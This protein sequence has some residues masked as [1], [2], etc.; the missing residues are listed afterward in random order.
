MFS[1]AIGEN[2][3]RPWTDRGMFDTVYVPGFRD[4]RGGDR[5]YTMAAVAKALFSRRL[6]DGEGFKIKICSLGTETITDANEALNTAAREATDGVI[7]NIDNMTNTIVVCQYFNEEEGA[8]DEL[9]EVLEPVAAA[10]PA[11][12]FHEKSETFLNKEM[13]AKVF[14]NEDNKAAFVITDKLNMPHWHLLSS[15][16]PTYVPKLFE[17]EPLRE[18]EK[19]VLKSMAL[20]GSNTFISNLAALE[21]LYDI[22]GKKIESLVSGFEVRQREIQVANVDEEIESLERQMRDLM[23]QYNEC[24]VEKDNANI[25][26]AGLKYFAEQ[27]GDD[28]SLVRFFKANKCLDV[29][30]VYESRITFIVRTFYENFDVDEYERFRENPRFF[31]ECE[32][33]GEFS[34]EENC[35]KIMDAM[36]L[37]GKI[38]MRMCAVYHLD[39]RGYVST[40]TD[41]EFPANCSEYIPNYHLDHHS[42]FGNY[43][44]V[45]TEYLGK[46]DTIGAINACIA[47]AKSVNIAESGATFNPMMRKVFQS[48]KKCFEL[49]D[50]RCVT[51]VEALKWLNENE[52]GVSEE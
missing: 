10:H 44:R 45:I 24:C 7:N 48:N 39:I 12:K 37:T 19:Q 14:I 35:K 43:E 42:C 1:R 26:R 11:W 8:F 9:K 31:A 51:P 34:S 29:V 50:G 2:M 21:E 38:K 33:R 5:D 30:D 49:P 3:L 28:D 46:G 13:K 18:D 40:T 20:H 27:A 17:N 22:R 16:L 23:N 25:R 52:E 36:F 41:Y 6:S 32:G 47:S 4:P 15:M